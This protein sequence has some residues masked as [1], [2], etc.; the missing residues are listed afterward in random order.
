MVRDGEHDDAVA[1]HVEFCALTGNEARGLE[2]LAEQA[3]A[4][5]RLGRPAEPA[6]LGGAV[7]LLM[8]RLT[9][10]GQDE[11]RVP[12]PRRPRVERR[13]AAG[14]HAADEALEVAARFDERNGNAR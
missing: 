1:D 7:A 13:D 10:L 12:G 9:E 14:A 3:G 8:R 6:V 2:I 4:P 11:Q 5:R